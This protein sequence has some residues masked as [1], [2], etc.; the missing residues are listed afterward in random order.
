M[1][2]LREVRCYLAAL[3]L[4]PAG[5][6]PALQLSTTV[7]MPCVQ[8]HA[9]LCSVLFCPSTQCTATNGLCRWWCFSSSTAQ[10]FQ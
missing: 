5:P 10:V 4:L 7:S 9:R 2:D 1:A 8:K 6:T 3:L